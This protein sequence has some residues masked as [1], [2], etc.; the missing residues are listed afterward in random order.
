MIDDKFLK[1]PDLTHQGDKKQ[2]ECIT[3]TFKNQIFYSI[4]IILMWSGE[5]YIYT[6]AHASSRQLYF[7]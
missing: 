7:L 5:Q 2:A 3:C 4:C 1:D 6:D